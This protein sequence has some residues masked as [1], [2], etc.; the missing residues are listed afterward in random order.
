MIGIARAAATQDPEWPCVQRLVPSL[1]VGAVWRGPPLESANTDWRENATVTALVA[2][3]SARR[4]PLD[5]AKRAIEEFVSGLGSDKNARLTALFA[6]ILE[7]INKDRETV[8]RGIK[9][10]A[11]RQRALGEKIAREA[12][13][14][15]ELRGGE[16]PETDSVL[17]D[18]SEKLSWDIRI[19]EERERSLSAVCEQPVLL[20]QRLFI[21]AR[22]IMT[23]LE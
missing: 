9:K 2:K 16:T 3:V 4:T 7:T 23:H 18:L 8:I 5:E 20:E 1:S 21:L 11:R 6:G 13:E 22:Q 12:A 14:L 19:F 10:Y 15:E 17:Q